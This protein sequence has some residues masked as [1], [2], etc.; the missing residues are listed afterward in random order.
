MMKAFDPQSQQQSTSETT[1]DKILKSFRS[2]TPV[3][4]RKVA[5]ASA[6]AGAG[7]IVSISLYTLLSNLSFIEGMSPEDQAALKISL[8]TIVESAITLVV[9]YQ[10]KPGYGDGVV[11]EKEEE[12]P[13]SS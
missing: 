6:A 11:V 13:K 2:E 4:N 5:F 1:S 10:V 8:F 7:A 12:D 9:G 3:V